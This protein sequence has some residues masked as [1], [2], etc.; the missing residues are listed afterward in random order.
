MKKQQA[1]FLTIILALIYAC[2]TVSIQA[3]SR[4]QTISEPYIAFTWNSHLLNYTHGDPDETGVK[5][6]NGWFFI[7]GDRSTDVMPDWEGKI[8]RICMQF[9]NVRAQNDAWES[10]RWVLNYTY[11]S[12]Y[13]NFTM[14]MIPPAPLESYT[15]WCSLRH[16]DSRIL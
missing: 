12:N 10:Y 4:N 2:F 15:H 16:D 3:A 7:E 5:A 11:P 14:Q 13:T 9:K 6:L 1:S 8:L